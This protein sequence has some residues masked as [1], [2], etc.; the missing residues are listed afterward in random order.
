MKLKQLFIFYLLLSLIIGLHT[1][2]L[3][4]K[5][6]YEKLKKYGRGKIL[7]FQTDVNYLELFKN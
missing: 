3:I 4:L 2:C 5:R 6:G 1:R 7:D